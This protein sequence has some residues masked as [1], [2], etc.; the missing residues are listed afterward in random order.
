MSVQV[1]STSIQGIWQKEQPRINLAFLASGRKSQQHYKEPA[2]KRQ[3]NPFHK[4]TECLCCI[5]HRVISLWSISISLQDL[6][7]VYSSMV[8]DFENWVVDKGAYQV[9]FV[10]VNDP[11]LFPQRIYVLL[12]SHN[13]PFLDSP[14]FLMALFSEMQYIQIKIFP[15]KGTTEIN[16]T[17]LP[18]L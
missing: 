18:T 5:K 15:I 13:H 6:L 14:T 7:C 17:F 1:L 3:Q 9:A 4:I 11:N 16:N 8:Q 2:P 10:L 12:T